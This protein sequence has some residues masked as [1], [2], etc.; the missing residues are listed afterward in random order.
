[1]NI[2]NVVNNNRHTLNKM[3]RSYALNA[4]D[5]LEL[6]EETGA[7]LTEEAFNAIIKVYEYGLIRG[8]NYVINQ[9]RRTK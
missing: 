3:P 2:A 6:I 5:V 7:P 1:M 9:T 4:S 8:H